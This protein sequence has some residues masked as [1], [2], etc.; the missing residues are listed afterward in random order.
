MVP[1][2]LHN[3][4][5]KFAL[6]LRTYLFDILQQ[7]MTRN[8]HKSCILFCQM[9]VIFPS[10]VFSFSYRH[11]W[12]HAMFTWGLLHPR[13]ETWITSEILTQLISK[14]CSFCEHS[15]Y[16][17]LGQGLLISIAHGALKSEN[18]LCWKKS[19]KQFFKVIH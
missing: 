11:T 9:S 7:F 14:N 3:H 1:S 13:A 6:S 10:G 18:I 8:T 5:P 17:A 2:L 16:L 4:I 19:G 15:K 12:W